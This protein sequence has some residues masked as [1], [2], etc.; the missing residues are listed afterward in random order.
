[1]RRATLRARP[2]LSLFLCL[3]LAVNLVVTAASASPLFVEICSGHRTILMPV[4]DAPD[5]TACETC[6]FCC[7]VAVPPEN[8]AALVPGISLIAHGVTAQPGLRSMV[9]SR[10]KAR[11]PPLL[12]I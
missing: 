8:R 10:P 2:H 1:M 6:V 4:P 12:S 11:A 7:V 5:E 9:L 3:I